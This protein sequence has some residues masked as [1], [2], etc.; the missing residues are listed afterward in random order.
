MIQVVDTVEC[1]ALHR[2]IVKPEAFKKAVLVQDAETPGHLFA[3]LMIDNARAVLVAQGKMDLH[4]KAGAGMQKLQTFRN[5]LYATGVSSYELRFCAPETFDRL[6]GSAQFDPQWFVDASF[7][8]LQ[9]RFGVWRAG[10]AT[11]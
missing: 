10:K 4:A 3:L 6:T 8:D 7:P 1:G 11:W 2:S 9:T 5:Q